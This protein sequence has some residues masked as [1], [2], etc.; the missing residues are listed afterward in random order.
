MLSVMPAHNS[1]LFSS[2]HWSLVGLFYLVIAQFSVQ[3]IS[4][5]R[6]DQAVLFTPIVQELN[7]C[8][9]SVSETNTTNLR[10]R[11]DIKRQTKRKQR[12]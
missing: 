3:N 8:V 6:V 2:Q 9:V 5:V 11:L 10:G 4:P 12:L 1:D 7:T